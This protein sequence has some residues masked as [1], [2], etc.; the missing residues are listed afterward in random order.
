MPSLGC[1]RQTH[2]RH[3]LAAARVQLLVATRQELCRLAGERVC[4]LE[5]EQRRHLLQALAVEQVRVGRAYAVWRI[6][7]IARCRADLAQQG[8]SASHEPACALHLDTACAEC[9]HTANVPGNKIHAIGYAKRPLRAIRGL[10]TC[11]ALHGGDRRVLLKVA[12]CTRRRG[13][14][15]LRELAFA[16]PG[17]LNAASSS[18][19]LSLHTVTVPRCAAGASP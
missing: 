16:R 9:K 4:Q 2:L 14:H 15:S 7:R 13:A 1:C 5:A 18:P 19:N 12:R 11:A 6:V 17:V 8:D 3:G 10:L